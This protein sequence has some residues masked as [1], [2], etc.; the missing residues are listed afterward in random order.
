[1]NSTND[2]PAS[3]PGIP[4]PVQKRPS[5]TQLEPGIFITLAGLFILIVGAKPGWFGWSH[6][7][8]VGFVKIAV[9]LLGLAVVCAGGVLCL[10]ALWKGGQR[11]IV[12]DIGVRLVGTGYVISVFSGMADVFG[13]GSQSPPLT[14]YF[15]PI[16]AAGVMLGQAVIALGFLMMIPYRSLFTSTK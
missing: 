1:M 12:S 16:Q 15:G 8:S 13:L 4:R 9:F 11:T 7:T 10:T 2:S 5:V 14:P 3:S 6:T